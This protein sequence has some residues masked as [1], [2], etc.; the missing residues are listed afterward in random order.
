MLLLR[1]IGARDA[2]G[3]CQFLGQTVVAHRAGRVRRRDA[4]AAEVVL[5]AVVV[6]ERDGDRGAARAADFLGEFEDGDMAFAEARGDGPAGA[7]FSIDRAGDRPAILG[8]TRGG[9]LQRKRAR[10]RR[11]VGR[12]GRRAQLVQDEVAVALGQAGTFAREARVGQRFEAQASDPRELAPDDD[13]V[14]VL[15]R[16]FT[17]DQERAVV[18]QGKLRAAG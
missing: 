8:E 9:V 11:V 14:G 12:D 4:E 6:V 2:E 10:G 13:A 18:L 5:A 16:R 7:A 1:T 15:V 17:G 3:I